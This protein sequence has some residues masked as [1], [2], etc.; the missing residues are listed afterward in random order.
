MMRASRAAR[1]ASGLRLAGRQDRFDYLSSAE[2]AERSR[3]LADSPGPSP[4]SGS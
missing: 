2:V 4:I 1:E 3:Q